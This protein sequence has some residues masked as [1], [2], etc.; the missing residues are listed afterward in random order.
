MKLGTLHL[1]LLLLA[2]ALFVPLFLTQ[3]LGPFDFWWWITINLL[4][5]L[6]LVAL[7]DSPWR[8]ALVSD[9]RD[10]PLRKIVLGLLSAAVLYGIFWV[11]NQASRYLFA[12]AAQDISGVY[13][14]RGQ[15]TALR[16]VLLMLFVI[17]PGEELFWRGFVQ[18][19]LQD[20][21]GPWSGWVLTTA[22]YTLIHLA[23]GN[24]ILV[25]AAGV[26]GAFWGWLYLRYRSMFL[27]A[28]SHTAWDVVIF[29]LFPLG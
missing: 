26:C 9:L 23:T 21:L 11:G 20:T 5:L 27:N 10:H 4:V 14:F 7:M 16:I 17:G 6:G 28:V 29:I 15:A 24:L 8:Q 19:H 13:A 3:G 2:L 22:I 25:L 1:R 12:G 18:R